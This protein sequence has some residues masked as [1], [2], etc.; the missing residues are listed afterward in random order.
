MTMI[1]DVSQ[2]NEY[3]FLGSC[4]MAV[5]GKELKDLGISCI[6]NLT[7]EKWGWEEQGFEEYQIPI[8]DGVA[9]DADTILP[10]YFDRMD[11]WLW[12][13]KKVFIHCHMGVSRTASFAIAWMMWAGYDLQGSDLRKLWSQCEDRVRMVRPV[14]EPAYTLKR[15][16][17]LHF[18]WDPYASA[19]SH[20]S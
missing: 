4:V 7:P 1:L 13:G 9:F 14:I 10:A 3:V 20:S 17:L 12:D 2:L 5:K 18:G 11:K 15:T 16:V 8:D 19:F 6:V